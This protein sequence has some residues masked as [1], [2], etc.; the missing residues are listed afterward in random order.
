MNV[1]V[2]IVQGHLYLFM[3]FFYSGYGI[4]FFCDVLAGAGRPR[5]G[6][7]TPVSY[8]HL[9][10]ARARKQV[11]RDITINIGSVHFL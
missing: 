7:V 1:A 11:N 2:I 10:W 3:F 5:L 8:T 9:V 6:R 4:I